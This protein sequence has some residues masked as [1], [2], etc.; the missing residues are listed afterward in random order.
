[1]TH[2]QK[3]RELT[4]IVQKTRRVGLALVL[5]CVLLTV[6][7]ATVWAAWGP[8]LRRELTSGLLA[9]HTAT[10]TRTPRPATP[11]PTQSV[12]ALVIPTFTPTAAPS[13]T[14]LPAVT[15]PP[16]AVAPA[17]PLP[18][19]LAAIVARY[20]MDPSRRFIVVDQ[21]RQRMIIWEPGQ[22]V[23][24]LMVS[25][26]DPAIGYPTP[27]WYGL[28]GRYWG[29]FYGFGVWA[30]DGWYLF[31]DPSGSNLIHS[32]PYRLVAGQK[33]Y[34]GLDALGN[35]PASHG[36][37]RLHPKDA[38]WFTAWGPQGVPLVVLPHTV[39]GPGG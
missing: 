36:C 39:V 21:D 4:I 24:E 34:E 35:Y 38:A 18:D 29:T 28:V 13:P 22:P 17:Q 12:V 25:T 6:L 16:L 7:S 2:S 3:V 8:L 20:G 11:P 14:P 27:A 5:A 37:I 9:L 31:D 33:V 10:P 1:L 15:P 32:L 30:D 23:R 26:G 19:D